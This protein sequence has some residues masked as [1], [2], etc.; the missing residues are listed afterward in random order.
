MVNNSTNIN[1]TNNQLPPSIT[2]YNKRN[3]DI[4]RWASR[5]WLQYRH[6]HVA[7]LSRLIWSIPPLSMTGSPTAIH[8][9]VY[10]YEQLCFHLRWPHTI[11][12]IFDSMCMY[13]VFRLLIVYT[14]NCYSVW[15]VL[16]I[17][18][19]RSVLSS[20]FI[21]CNSEMKYWQPLV[22]IFIVVLRYIHIP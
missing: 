3:H 13:N 10:T 7:G 21:Q 11:R 8:I 12:K 18:H 17:L 16:N 9:Y 22:I 19:I 20:L 4:W 2:E 15:Y 5:S 6:I 1:K 14:L